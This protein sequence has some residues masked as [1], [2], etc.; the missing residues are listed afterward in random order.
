MTKRKS[1]KSVPVVCGAPDAHG[2]CFA[3]LLERAFPFRAL[4]QVIVASANRK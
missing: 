4:D 3:T 2:S 1:F